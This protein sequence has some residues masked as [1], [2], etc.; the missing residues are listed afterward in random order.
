MNTFQMNQNRTKTIT[1]TS[2]LNKKNFC[3]DQ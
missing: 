1:I 3:T 2:E